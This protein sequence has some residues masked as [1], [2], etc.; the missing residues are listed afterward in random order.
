[1]PSPG[2]TSPAGNT[3]FRATIFSAKLIGLVSA[4]TTF[5]LGSP[6][7][8]AL[9]YGRSPPDRIT[10]CVSASRPRRNA[11]SGIASPAR[12]RSSREKSVVVRMPMLSQFCR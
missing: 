3:F 10:S 1:M 5:G 12:M 8:R 4:L 6:A 2:S 7:R 11:S 9:L